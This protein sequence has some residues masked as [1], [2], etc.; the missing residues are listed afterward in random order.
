[1][2][3]IL[4]LFYN[5]DL[6]EI[7]P[8]EPDKLVTGYID[9]TNLIVTGKDTRETT[10]KLVALHQKAERWAKRAAS[11]FA[12][13]KYK[14][15]HFIPPKHL[16]QT[17]RSEEEVR[18]DSERP[19]ILQLL[20]GTTQTIE[21][22]QEVTYLGVRLNAQLSGQAQAKHVI[23]T[24]TKQINALS[25]VGAS[26]W[27]LQVDELRKIYLAVIIPR[28]LYGLSTWYSPDPRRG[29]IATNKKTAKT[30]SAIQHKALCRISGAFRT[31]AK[32][33]LEVELAIPPI[34][35]TMRRQVEAAMIRTRVS[36]LY[37]KIQEIRDR[38]GRIRA[39][40][41]QR[42]P[43]YRDQ[44]PLQRFEFNFRTSSTGNTRT[45]LETVIPGSFA[46]WEKPPTVTI[47][48]DA[49]EATK[50][51]NAICRAA[52][53]DPDHLIT[54][55]DGS[56]IGGWVGAAA[57]APK[58]KKDLANFMGSSSESNIAAA[59]VRGLTLAT[60]IA[61]LEQR[62][63]RKLT[64]FSD[65]QAAMQ[66]VKRPGNQPGQYLIREFSWLLHN[67]RRRN[68]E[69]HIHWIPSHT[70]IGGNERVD[71]IAKEATGWKRH[72]RGH[73]AVPHQ[74]LRQ[75]RS[76]IKTQNHYTSN[77]DWEIR[78]TR[79]TTGRALYRY[80][81]EFS[82]KH[83]NLKTIKGLK[84]GLAS[85]ITQ[86]RTGKIALNSYLYRIGKADSPACQCRH[87]QQTAE[88]LLIS[89]ASFKEL[90]RQVWPTGEPTDKKLLTTDPKETARSAKF[91][92]LTGK[93]GQFRE[94]RSEQVI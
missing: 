94:T 66:A 79:G 56:Q 41:R 57:S 61:S 67:N 8:N 62:A 82:T 18:E 65:S 77:V 16:Q 55:T 5:A 47:H 51:H 76:A 44:S 52:N 31:T 11:V 19:L 14:L 27:G 29:H 92:Y 43:A 87:E 40:T 69:V 46:P 60:M 70:G 59:E 1:M 63:P 21:P 42:E 75:L 33:A 73:R 34:D 89:C 53:S 38:A 50:S 32:A 80:A 86:M 39:A 90:R 37:N 23:E 10:R 3:P 81:P 30:L 49:E 68:T 83:G 22:V 13:A 85:I 54:Y 88:H 15:I 25:A 35:I 7:S 36:P 28:M 72:G 24:V 91:L 6:L 48:K 64:I 20:D 17:G 12:P 84:K 78:W 4:Y 93:L 71:R 9:D 26:T 2:S 58:L 74:H 45:P